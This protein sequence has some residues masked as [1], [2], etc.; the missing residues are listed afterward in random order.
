MVTVTY[1]IYFPDLVDVSTRL[2]TMKFQD[3]E[4]AVRSRPGNL[5]DCHST[6]P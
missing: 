4:A 3:T 6:I 1:L 2:Y 5:P